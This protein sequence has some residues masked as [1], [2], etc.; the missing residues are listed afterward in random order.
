MFAGHTTDKASMKNVDFPAHAYHR[1]TFE[2]S[3]PMLAAMHWQG[4]VKIWGSSPPIANK[5][6]C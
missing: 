6:H 3:L 2:M 5:S 1:A 4:T